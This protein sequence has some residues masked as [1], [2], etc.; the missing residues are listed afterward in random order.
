MN[1]S[2]T[3][4]QSTRAQITSQIGQQ[5]EQLQKLNQQL[6][7]VN[8]SY[9]LKTIAKIINPQ[10]DTELNA[11]SLELRSQLSQQI[12]T[13]ME[14]TKIAANTAK[15]KQ[16]ITLMRDAVRVNLGTV[17]A[18]VCLITVWRLTRWVRLLN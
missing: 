4:Y 5:T 14:K 6:K 10:S 8:T 9:E 13:I 11:S 16:S 17:L 3:L 18:G 2:L 12:Q 7:I 15:R 1:N